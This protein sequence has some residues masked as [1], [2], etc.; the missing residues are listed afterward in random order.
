MNKISIFKTEIAYIKNPHFQENIERMLELLPDYFFEIP[1]SS[2][3]KY[4]PK[5][6][7]GEGGLVRH[8]KVAVRI[9]YELLEDDLFR[10]DFD[11]AK[12]D[13]IFMALLLHDGLKSGY[14]KQK[15]TQAAHPLLMSKYLQEHKKQF[16]LT[17]SEL[18]FICDCIETHSGPWTKDYQGKE[19]LS[20][21][22]TKAQKFVHLCDYLASR[23]FLEVAFQ[24]G[25]MIDIK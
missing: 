5:F 18:N 20:R 25:E 8:T 4:H 22:Q 15:Y 21:P 6:A 24:D 3:G 12:Q 14:P 9:A 13:M 2:G 17:D 19:I 7:S 1:A 23:K 10:E 16:T 11:I